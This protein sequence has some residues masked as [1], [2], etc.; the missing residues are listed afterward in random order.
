M[1]DNDR[2]ETARDVTADD[3]DNLHDVPTYTPGENQGSTKVGGAQQDIYQRT[4]KAAPT[5]VFPSSGSAGRATPEPTE[6]IDV[7]RDAPAA[8]DTGAGTSTVAVDRHAAAE[9]VAVEPEPAPAAAVA[10]PKARR[11]TIDLGL[12]LLRLFVGG[13]LILDSLKVFFRLG[14]SDG[15]TGLENAFS[16]Y[17]FGDALAI[18]LPT[19]ELAAGVFLL[20]GLLTPVAAMVAVTVTAFFAI[21][22]LAESGAGANPLMWEAAVWLPVLLLAACV[23]LQFTGPGFYSVDAGRSWARRPLASSWIFAVLGIAA[24]AVLWWFGAGVNPLN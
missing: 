10:E 15:I 19:L 20:L 3:F 21:H 7:K 14:G 6:I 8:T 11:G 18:V 24:A 23:S 13:Y 2:R 5:E 12:F 4:G 16:D 9:P 17:P 1:K 22:A